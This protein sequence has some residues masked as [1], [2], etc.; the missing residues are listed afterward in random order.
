MRILTD[1]YLK[2]E[3]F[4]RFRYKSQKLKLSPFWPMATTYTYLTVS[5]FMFT[6]SFKNKANIVSAYYMREL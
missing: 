2:F 5:Y 6:R 3:Q 1:D 4:S